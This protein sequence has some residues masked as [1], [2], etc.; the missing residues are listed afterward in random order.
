M[1]ERDSDSEESVTT[2]GRVYTY[3]IFVHG[4]IATFI[5]L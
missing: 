4:S 1:T 3:V 2:K 5:Y